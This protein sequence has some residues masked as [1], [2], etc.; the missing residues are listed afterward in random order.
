MKIMPKEQYVLMR[1][2]MLANNIGINS[3]SDLF[4][5]AKRIAKEREGA[6]LCNDRPKCP[7]PQALG[8]IKIMGHCMCKLFGNGDGYKK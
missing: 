5:W 4:S 7:C 2:F 8:E 1:N 3:K 6:C